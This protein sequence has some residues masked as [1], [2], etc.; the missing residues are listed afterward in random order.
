[1]LW[2]RSIVPKIL[3]PNP[4]IASAAEKCRG[5][6]RVVIYTSSAAPRPYSLKYGTYLSE[7]L[8]DNAIKTF[9]TISTLKA[10]QEA[11]MRRPPMLPVQHRPQQTSIS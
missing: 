1:M 2:P 6:G 7:V 9:E 5:Y 8:T 11:T 10:V 3:W 4:P